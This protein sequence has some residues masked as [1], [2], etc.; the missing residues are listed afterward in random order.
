MKR[1]EEFLT[2]QAL[3]VF[4]SILQI[5]GLI[6]IIFKVAPAIITICGFAAIVKIFL[7]LKGHQT[8]FGYTAA[9][10]GLGIIILWA[11]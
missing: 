6:L 9:F 5:L 11:I 3:S 2:I 7:P 10:A 8:P 4:C 1:I